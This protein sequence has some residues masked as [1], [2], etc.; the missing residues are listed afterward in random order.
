MGTSPR[1]LVVAG[2]G[3]LW[4][5]S[6]AAAEPALAEIKHQGPVLALA[7]SADGKTLASAG[8]D[9][10]IILTAFPGGKESARI[11]TGSPIS[12]IVFSPNAKLLGVKVRVQ[13]GPLAIWDIGTKKQ[14]QK[15]A[16]PGYTCHHLAFTP[17]NQTLVAA[18]P[19]EHMVWNFG[20]GGGY[21]SRMGAVPAGAFAAVSPDGSIAAWGQPK[22]QLQFFHVGPRKFEHLPLGPARALAFSTDGKTIA[23]SQ[24]DKTI[25]L[26]ELGGGELR[27]LE[28]LREPATL[29]HFAANGKVLAA[30]GAQDSVIRLWDVASGRLRRRVTSNPAGVKALALSPDGRI[31][32]L[33]AADKVLLWSVAT[34]ELG[35]LGPP[36]ALS[37]DELRDAWNDLG[38]SDH[39]KAETAF[40]KFAAAGPHA[41]DFLKRQ[42]RAFAVPE[43]DWENVDRRLRD[44]NSPKY[45]VRNKA[46]SELAKY[47]E[48][49]VKVVERYLKSNPALE[50]KQRASKLLEQA[51]DPPLTPDRLRALEA[52]ELVELLRGTEARR[53]LEE[54]ARDSLIAQIRQ[55]AQDALERLNRAEKTTE[56]PKKG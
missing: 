39:A 10:I 53:A 14:T 55:A 30:G 41:L 27:K 43:I 12:G 31:L 48:V 18:G 1:T 20:K 3:L 50:G 6:A 52:V 56:S 33:A 9:G 49:I 46:S 22:G 40:R 25:Q 28:G 5:V 15:L 7:W 4:L 21:G 2:A 44:L 51:K 38:H 26:R 37:A 45:S 8:E 42:T 34:R 17:D 47:G 24:D 11:E 29:L 19:G 36:V 16:F 23:L 35:D 32:A 13:D 54:L